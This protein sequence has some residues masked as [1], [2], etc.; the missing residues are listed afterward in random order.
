VLGRRRNAAQGLQSGGDDEGGGIAQAGRQRRAL[1]QLAQYQIGPGGEL[2]HTRMGGLADDALRVEGRR[3]RR[4]EGMR[5]MSRAQSEL[6]DAAQ[7]QLR[8]GVRELLGDEIERRIRMS[9]RRQ[10]I[11]FYL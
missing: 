3:V 9:I 1:Q 7:A 5:L 11:A 8:G 2:N 4:L 10:G 6:F